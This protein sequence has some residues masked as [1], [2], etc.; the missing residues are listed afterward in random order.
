MRLITV[1]TVIAASLAAA[2]PHK[3]RHQHHQHHQRAAAPVAQPDDPSAT[4]I[5]YELNG[6]QISQSD[7]DQGIKNGTLVFANG[8]LQSNS[9]SAPPSTPAP[10]QYR[11]APSTSVSVQAVSTSTPS[12]SDDP[13][14]A[15]APAPAPVPAPAPAA[16]QPQPEQHSGSSQQPQAQ[17][18]GS[19]SGSSG[20]FSPSVNGLETDF[21][22]GTIDCSSFPSDYGAMHLDWLN[23]GGWTGIQKPGSTSGGYSNIET[24]PGGSA[25]NGDYCC[26]GCF[27]SYACPPGF[28]KS[29]W[30]TTQG[31]TGQSIGGIQCI[32]GKLH[33]TNQQMSNKLCMTGA[34]EVPVYV[35]NKMDKNSAVCRTDYPGEQHVLRR[36]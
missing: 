36:R 17:S 35:Q 26:E 21:P 14:P 16:P 30:P 3:R 9:E 18:Y 31:A 25:S 5:V 10:W 4:V 28:Q 29:Q 1:V 34:Q 20:S 12:P 27:C 11:S 32:N 2:S 7:V 8:G 24:V 33:L 15:P 22:S 19:P 23:L 6:K 13:S